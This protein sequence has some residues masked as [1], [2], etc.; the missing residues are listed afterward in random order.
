MAMLN[1][2]RVYNFTMGTAIEREYHPRN[3]S[4]H[5]PIDECVGFNQPVDGNITGI[6]DGIQWTIDN[7]FERT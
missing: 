3:N 5:I 1:N 4:K 7:E 2:Q 6:F